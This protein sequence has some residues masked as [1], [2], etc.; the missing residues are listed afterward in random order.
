VPNADNAGF[1]E[2]CRQRELRLQS[3]TRCGGIRHPPR[4]MCPQCQCLEYEWRRA[5][6][7]GT[8]YTFTI[9][10]APTLP[11]F[12][13]TVPYNVIVVHLHEGP[14]MVS[15]LVGCAAEQITI[16]MRVEVVF[17][18]VAENVSLPKF[19]PTAT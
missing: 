1:W 6:G 2:G 10:H 14:F 9:V 12:Q 3:C 4:P 8:V 16:G 11:A 15:N 5:S 18:D 7:Q 13:N 19:R 17:E